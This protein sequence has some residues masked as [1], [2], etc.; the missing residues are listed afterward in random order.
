[1][2]RFRLSLAALVLACLVLAAMIAVALPLG[3]LVYRSF[4]GPDGFTL[5]HYAAY[6]KT[7]GLLTALVNTAF[8]GGATVALVVPLAFAFAYGLERALLPGKA[9]L[10]AMA[11]V[12]L[13]VPSLL[14]ALVLI[15]LFGRQ[16]ILTPLL[17]GA[18]IYGFPGVLFADAI[19]TLPHAIII[20][21]TALRNADARLYEQATLLGAGSWRKFWTITI[22]SARYGL[23][24]SALVV[25]ALTITDIGAPK[26]I[27][28]D[29]DVLAI[30]IYK[31]VLGQQNFEL[32]AVAAILLMLP[33]FLAIL[34]ERAAAKRHAASVSARAKRLSP[35]RHKLRDRL[36]G[37]VCYS[38][39][40][41]IGLFLAV[42]Q[43]V[44]LVRLW[45]Y[46]LSLTT[47]HYGLDRYDGGGWDAVTNSVILA[48]ATALCGTAI[49]FLGAYISERMKEAA[50][51]RGLFSRIALLPAAVPGLALGLAYVLFFNAPANPL[52]IIY[53]SVALL[54]IANIT[55]FYTVA[56]LSAVGAVKALDKE[57]EPVAQSL[58]R[59]RFSVLRLVALPVSA[60]V[61][62]EIAL[63]LF[64]NAMTTVSVVM[65]LYPP[66]FK[67]AAVAVLNMDDAGDLA[68]AAAMGMVIFYVNLAA[69]IL[70]HWL[71]A[72]RGRF[73]R[74]EILVSEAAA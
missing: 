46:D 63:Y 54:L 10:S 20:L 9:I 22:P 66:G 50:F 24:S 71:F 58:G 68:P 23:V 28:G 6:I 19:A 7:P 11:A 44:A 47:A 30:V 4:S 65:F 43:L 21:R 26:V 34:F 38:L 69:R 13:L 57:L 64:V 35:V 3:I 27:G 14:P 48:G 25:F 53:G 67:L 33:S 5:A 42:C 52:H 62:M 17:G 74:P 8:L 41:G 32:G 59:S 72:Q 51:L 45:P 31:Q 73:N 36:V 16:G 56:H 70:G 55:H 2:A 61:L 1:M 49:A 40:G 18:N 29:F 15:Y 60:P 37:L 39:A 12:P